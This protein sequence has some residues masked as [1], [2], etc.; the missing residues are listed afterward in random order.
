MP[1]NQ[2][3]KTESE[4]NTRPQIMSNNFEK[5]LSKINLPEFKESDSKIWLSDCKYLLLFKLLKM[6]DKQIFIGL[7]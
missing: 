7:L 3:I 6:T 1:S 4:I 2:E 5:G